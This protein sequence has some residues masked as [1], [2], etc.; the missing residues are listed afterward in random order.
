M[1]SIQAGRPNPLGSPR[2]FG[3]PRVTQSPRMVNVFEAGAVQASSSSV[4]EAV[5]PITS[6]SSIN[7]SAARV[8]RDPKSPQTRSALWEPLHDWTQLDAADTFSCLAGGEPGDVSL[9]GHGRIKKKSNQTEIDFYTKLSEPDVES[10]APQFCGSHIS[11]GNDW[12]YFVILEDLTAGF[13]KPTILDLQIGQEHVGSGDAGTSEYLGMRLNGMLRHTNEGPLHQGKKWGGSVEIPM[14]SNE[15]EEF[16]TDSSGELRAEVAGSVVNFLDRL[17]PW[18]KA[19]L[20]LRLTGSSLLVVY[21]GDTTVE[22]PA[23]PVVKMIDFMHVK[24]V[25]DNTCDESYLVGVR[26]LRW[27]LERL[28]AYCELVAGKMD[29]KE[30]KKELRSA[31]KS[32]DA[33]AQKLAAAEKKCL[34]LSPDR[35]TN[36][37]SVRLWHEDIMKENVARQVMEQ[38]DNVIAAFLKAVLAKHKINAGE[39]A[40]VELLQWRLQPLVLDRVFAMDLCDKYGLNTAAVDDLLKWKETSDTRLRELRYVYDVKLSAAPS[41][42]SYYDLLVK[43][44]DVQAMLMTQVM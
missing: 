2:D 10:L 21:E 34:A 19:Q 43:Q 39:D 40:F 6:L 35:G 27:M 20:G 4:S 30:G 44:D 13:S 14:F 41:L 32:L 26:N 9:A 25:R 1:A 37:N 33:A 3:S 23:A 22:E 42:P 31:K 38:E 18:M 36:T 15:L 17:E 29:T 16:F 24:M 5:P 12:T 8:P 7:A 28:V 11:D